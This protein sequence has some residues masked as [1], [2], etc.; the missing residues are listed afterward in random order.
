MPVSGTWIVKMDAE[1]DTLDGAYVDY[2]R[3]IAAGASPG[4]LLQIEFT[5]EDGTD[6]IDSVA[7]GGNF[8]DIIWVNR[9]GDLEITDM[10]SGFIEVF[11]RR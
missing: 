9:K 8:I 4:D 11:L 6:V 7:D 5:T 3:W 10:D 1:L 2:I